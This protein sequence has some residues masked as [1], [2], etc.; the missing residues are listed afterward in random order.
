MRRI[1][2]KSITADS[3]WR[4]IDLQPQN[5]KTFR[6]GVY[7]SYFAISYQKKPNFLQEKMC[8]N[9]PSFLHRRHHR[10][11][12]FAWMVAREKASFPTKG[13][14]DGLCTHTKSE[15]QGLGGLDEKWWMNEGWSPGVV[16]KGVA[17]SVGRT[18]KA[19]WELLR[20]L[21]FFYFF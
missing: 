9:T 16:Q 4:K 21:S 5:R 10:H 2:R 8:A 12:G 1:I 6:Q 14:G 20:Q 15:G 17:T 19:V 18:W 11:R 3:R 13:D 7:V